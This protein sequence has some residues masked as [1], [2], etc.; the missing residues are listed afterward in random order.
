MKLIVLKDNLKEGFFSVE[1]AVGENT[2]LP[3]LKTIL[4]K[5][6]KNKIRFS[7]TNLEIGATSFINAK[8]IEEGGIAVPV[9]AFSNIIS[10]IDAERINIETNGNNLIIKTDNYQAKIQGIKEEEFPIIPPITDQNQFIETETQVI[11]NS[12]SSITNAAQVSEIRPELAGI[13][14]DF[15]NQL[16]K[17]VATDSFRLG[18]KTITNHLF[19][20]TFKKNFRAIVPLK[21][22]QEVTRIFK[23][24]TTLNIHIDPSQILFKTQNQELI[25]RLIDGNYPDYEQIIPKNLETEI[26]VGREQLINALK[27]VGAITGKINDV[28]VAAKPEEKTLEVHAAN[29]YVGENTYLVPAKIKGKGFKNIAFNWRYLNDGLKAIA[30]KNVIFQATNDTKPALIKPEEDETFFYIVMPIKTG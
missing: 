8:I 3:V 11:T 7:A 16:L 14:F 12:I 4:F 17:L 29:Q 13:L 5:T 6:E 10:N 19:K 23:N 26:I 21:T 22:C 2:N 18:E 15:Q 25:S 28:K 1:N 9:A 20:T 24:N 30:S 27:L